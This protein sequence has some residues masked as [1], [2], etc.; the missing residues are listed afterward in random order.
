LTAQPAI[1]ATAPIVEQAPPAVA[2]LFDELAHLSVRQ[3][4][5]LTGIRSK[6]FRRAELLAMVAA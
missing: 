5:E 2:P 6:R 4:R 3:L 1:Q